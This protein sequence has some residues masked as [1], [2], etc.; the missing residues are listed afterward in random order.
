[1]RNIALQQVEGPEEDLT[2]RMKMFSE[3]DDMENAY[4]YWRSLGFTTYQSA[5]RAGYA[6]PA[7]DGRRAEARPK[8]VGAI[9]QLFDKVAQK[10]EITRDKVMEGY[11]EVLAIAREQS[12]PK[13]ML[14]A[15][16]AIAA[17]SGHGP[18]D[19]KELHIKASGTIS[20]KREELK[21]ASDEQL[22]EIL[23]RERQLGDPQIIED[24][25]YEEL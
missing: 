4:V 5:K 15:W 23:G 3:L 21:T 13:I 10:Y 11:F 17:S 8:V 9:Q 14:E 18:K 20:V 12:E 6:N 19:V 24:A 25:I 1:M 7:R 2:I 22:L 16:N